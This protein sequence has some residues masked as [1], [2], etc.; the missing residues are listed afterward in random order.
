[1]ARRKWRIMKL[2]EGGHKRACVVGRHDDK[3][4]ADKLALQ[5]QFK[6]NALYEVWDSDDADRY[7]IE[8]ELLNG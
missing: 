3:A 8:R 6:F 5:L 1:M 4:V 2:Y 7:L